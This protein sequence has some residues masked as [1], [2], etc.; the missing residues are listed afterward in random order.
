[1]GI[2]IYLSVGFWEREWERN[3]FR[4]SNFHTT[5]AQATIIGDSTAD[6]AV[7]HKSFKQLYHEH[8]HTHL[9]K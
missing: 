6:A 5:D 4:I 2:N 9:E 8:T 1:M 3:L 7:S